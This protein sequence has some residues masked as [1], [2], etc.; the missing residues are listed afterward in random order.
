MKY[1]LYIQNGDKVY[2]PIL[3]GNIQWDTS[4]KGT[5]GKLTFTVVKDD[6]INFQEGNPVIF[7]VNG[8]NIFYGFIFVKGRDKDQLINVTAYDQIRYL[9][10]KDTYVY[11]NKKANELVK[12]IAAD[13]NLQTGTLADTGYIIPRRIE[14]NQTLMDMIYTALDLTVINTSK[15]FVL[16]DDFGK[17]TLKD[18]EVMKV[19]II[20]GDE[21]AEDFFYQT[22]IDTDTYNKIKLV[23][24]D[25]EN[26]KREVY[27]TQDSSTINQ[28]GVLQYYEVVNEDLNPAQIKAQSD[29]LLKMKNRKNRSLEIKN[30]IGDIRVRGGSSVMVALKD[31]GDVSIN[32]YLLVEKCSHIFSNSEHWMTLELRGNMR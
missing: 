12:M 23:R 3:E 14:E 21:T 17:L 25:K 27:I 30:C 8:V 10:N 22:D 2:A 18:V 13:F 24:E 5:P 4:R 15:L 9:K 1:E 20:V 11:G 32:Q 19:P 31:V 28:W 16:Y 26:G 29:Y 6:V 7:K